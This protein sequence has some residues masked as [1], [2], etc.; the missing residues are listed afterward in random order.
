MQNIGKYLNVRNVFLG[1]TALGSL[2]AI[3]CEQPKAVS[4]PTKQA[5]VAEV[6]SPAAMPYSTAAPMPYSTADSIFYPSPTATSASKPIATSGNLIAT[7]VSYGDLS[8][9]RKLLND[10]KNNYKD[11]GIDEV[12]DILYKVS[13]EAYRCP[14]TVQIGDKIVEEIKSIEEIK[15]QIAPQDNKRVIESYLL[16]QYFLTGRY[17]K[18]PGEVRSKLPEII[19]DLEKTACN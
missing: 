9:A 7:P 13:R 18:Y 10:V 5:Y 11:L 17:A 3:S 14:N 16:D 12:L 1:I 8:T 15:N 4:E 2:M 19:Y 6:P